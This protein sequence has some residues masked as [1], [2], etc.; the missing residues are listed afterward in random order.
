MCTPGFDP[1][2]LRIGTR[3][4]MANATQTYLTNQ[5]ARNTGPKNPNTPV[6]LGPGPGLP[7]GTETGN[8][9]PKNPRFG[10]PVTLN[11]SPSPNGQ[12]PTAGNK[13]LTLVDGNSGITS[14]NDVPPGTYGPFREDLMF[15]K[16][17][18][19]IN[20]SQSNGSRSTQTSGSA[21]GSSGQS[22]I[23]RVGANIN[24]AFSS[25]FSRIPNAPGLK[26]GF[27]LGRRPGDNTS[28]T[29]LTGPRGVVDNAPVR[30]RKAGGRQSGR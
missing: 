24:S 14:V 12:K 17:P 28:D 7:P 26:L 27:L 21:G 16:K 22:F 25:A 9:G 1:S 11:V 15:S 20:F 4:D 5:K 29:I 2:K 10:E 19:V 8:T 6:D 3:Q 13:G 23:D 18:G 30:K